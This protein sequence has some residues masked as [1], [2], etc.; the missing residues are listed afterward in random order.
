[1][2]LKARETQ[3]G[4]AASPEDGTLGEAG[5]SGSYYWRP[6]QGSNCPNERGT[7]DKLTLGDLQG[8]TNMTFCG[9]DLSE[10][11][12]DFSAHL[13]EELEKPKELRKRQ[14]TWKT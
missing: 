1:M 8:G 5:M 11:S 12:H 4:P 3:P 7:T 14:F 6:L 13:T 9:L 2:V 10:F